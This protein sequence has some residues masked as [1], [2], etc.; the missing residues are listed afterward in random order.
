[1]STTTSKQYTVLDLFSGAG[2]MSYGFHSHP[3]FKIVGA[4]DAQRGKPSSGFGKLECNKTYESNIGI[5]PHNADI[6]KL[7][8]EELKGY[9]RD[10]GHKGKIDVLISCAPCTGFSRTVR[11][12][13]VEDDPRNSLISKSADFVEVLKPSIFL[14]ENVGELLSGKFSYHFESLKERLEALN[15]DIHAYVHKLE[16][17]G[18]PQRRRRALVIACKKGLKLKTL[19]DLWEGYSIAPSA[20]TVRRAIAHL[21]PLHAGDTSKHDSCHTSPNFSEKGLKRL[22]LIPN[23]GGSW[24]DLLNQPGGEEYLI[25]SMRKYSDIG[26]VGPHP[27]VY[28]RMAWDAP[29]PTIKRECSNTGNGRYAHPEQDRHCTVR[30]MGIL[31]GFPSSYQFSADSLSN[32]Y[33]H[34]GDAVPPLISYQMAWVAN[35]IL[36]GKRPAICDVILKGTHL[37]PG[38]ITRSREKDDKP[39]QTELAI[40]A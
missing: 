20:T 38:D 15:Y 1:M 27:D 30:E 10:N 3:S 12:N 23:D 6:S 24:F 40:S 16:E 37:K 21:E 31:Q 33:R 29:A 14:M 22:S 5:K 7:T 17:F 32:M 35:W 39:I 2:G 25:P 13:L 26:K 11:R 9:L 8:E 18:L 34:T 4:V 28:G 19:E 36:G